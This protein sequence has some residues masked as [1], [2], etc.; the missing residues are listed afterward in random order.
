[1]PPAP[2]PPSSFRCWSHWARFGH[3]IFNF[4]LPGGLKNWMTF[5]NSGTILKDRQKEHE[6]RKREWSAMEHCHLG[7]TW[8]FLNSQQLWLAA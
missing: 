4:L 8:P 7:M 1:M 2:T 5:Q 3:H 6:N